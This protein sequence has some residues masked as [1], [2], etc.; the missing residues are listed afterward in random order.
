MKINIGCGHRTIPGYINC[1]INPNLPNID[2]VC[3][4]DNIPV[5]PNTYD[6]VFASHVIEHVPFSRAKN[7]L[8]EWL[9]VLKPGGLLIA[10]TP[11]VER[12]IRNY[13]DGRWIDDFEKLTP[14]EKEFCSF[15]GKPNRTLHLNFKIF[16]SDIQW[17][18]HYANYDADL[19]VAFCLDAG[20]SKAEAVQ[21]EPSLIVKAWK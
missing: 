6:E 20:F 7:A 18:L 5:E 8:R 11:N 12:N 19:L 14:A 10:D 1:D 17:D 15:N 2:L 16:S 9:R 13:T 4:L 21:F 3:E